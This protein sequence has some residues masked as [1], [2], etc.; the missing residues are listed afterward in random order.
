MASSLHGETADLLARH[1][2]G[3]TY[4]AGDPAALRTAVRAAVGKRAGVAALADV[5]DAQKLYAGYV[6]F[7]TAL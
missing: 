1:A 2:A 4:T 3:V 6:A 5:F 7:A